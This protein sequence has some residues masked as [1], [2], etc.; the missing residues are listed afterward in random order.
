MPRHI[1][2]VPLV[3]GLEAEQVGRGSG[4]GGGSLALPVDRGYVVV[5]VGCG[6]FS[7]ICGLG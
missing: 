3:Q 2:V 6:P 5:Q 4:S 7:D 1:S